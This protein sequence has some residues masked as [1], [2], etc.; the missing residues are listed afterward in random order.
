MI[1]RHI[2]TKIMHRMVEHNGI[3]HFG[4][5]TADD[6]SQDMKGQTRQIC[7]TIDDRLAEAGSSK[8]KLLTA[9]IFISDFSRKELMNE[10]WV[11]W[12]SGEFLPTRA[13][14]GVADLGEDCLVEVVVSAAKS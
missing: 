7:K 10:A 13:T 14:I 6:C 3:I 8:E 12:L 9:M 5:V 4:G 11:E 1:T 2:R